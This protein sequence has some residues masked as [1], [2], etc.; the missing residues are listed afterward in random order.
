MHPNC[1][2][3]SICRQLKIS[4]PQEIECSTVFD[5]II[6]PYYEMLVLYMHAE[7]FLSIEE[8]RR[9]LAAAPF[10][11]E[12]AMLWLLGG[13]GMRVSEVAML[14]I[15]HIDRASGFIYITKGKGNKARTCVC[16]QTALDALE[17]HLQG[18]KTGYVFEG[19]KNGHISTRMIQ[20][21]LDD[22]ADAA[23]LQEI[24]SGKIRQRKRVT[25]HLLRHSFSRWSLDAG[26]DISYLQQQLGHSSLATTAIYLQ[27]RPNH[28]REAY[29]KSRFNEM[30]ELPKI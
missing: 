8:W 27:A 11:R 24:R 21:L 23:G 13:C 5:C 22:I 20:T 4:I 17:A 25:P 18:R 7:D 2:N 15:E 26:I 10:A 1:N 19:R 30:L 6:F 28:R 16:P 12:I 9:L 3:T 14:R 29:K